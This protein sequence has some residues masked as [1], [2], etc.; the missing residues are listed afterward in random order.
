[1]TKRTGLFTM[2]VIFFLIGFWVRYVKSSY[3]VNFY[4]MEKYSNDAECLNG[5]LFSQSML[6]DYM[7]EMD[8]H[9]W[10]QNLNAN[11]VYHYM[12]W[13]PDKVTYGQDSNYLDDGMIGFIGAHGGVN[14]SNHIYISMNRFNAITNSCKVIPYDQMQLGDIANGNK[15]LHLDSC[16][17]M[18]VDDNAL[19][20]WRPVFQGVHQIDGFHGNGWISDQLLDDYGNF[21]NHSHILAIAREWVQE[22]TEFDFD[23]DVDL[24]PVAYTGRYTE[25][26]CED[27]LTNEK[28]PTPG[29][30]NLLYAD[31]P[32]P[33][34]WRRHYRAGC[35]PNAGDP[36]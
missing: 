3:D 33:T 2:L 17:S 30:I 31:T 11:Y 34:V 21:A 19:Q 10:D 1:M 14:A 25:D 24:C 5:P 6:Q 35:D 4:L 8:E 23:G 18:H 32:S 13:D 9:G 16:H 20:S 29:Q 28:Y 27:I 36:L 15:W 26:S 22:L 7:D 12:F